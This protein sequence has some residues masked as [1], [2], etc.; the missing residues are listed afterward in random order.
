M[1]VRLAQPSDLR[2]INDIYNFE[3]EHTTATFDTIPVSL[4]A[5]AVWLEEHQAPAHPAV[6]AEIEDE[7]AGWASL[8]PWSERCAYA[9]SAEISVYV[10]RDYRHRGIGRALMIDA[11]DRGRN[12][13]L[14][15]IL[16]RISSAEGPAS[17]GL[18]ESLGFKV[19]G[20]LHRVGDKLGKILD[21]HMLELQLDE[22]P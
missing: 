14:G 4:E 11:V 6:V 15:V 2:A 9:R 22:A 12:A 10:H 3:V 5:R 20:T 7:V 13:G 18:H 8:S 1:R 21:V 19:V 16:S 17:L